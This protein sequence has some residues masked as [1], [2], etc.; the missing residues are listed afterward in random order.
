M[1]VNRTGTHRTESKTGKYNLYNNLNNEPVTEIRYISESPTGL[2]WIG[3]G[4]AGI[5][6]FNPHQK[7]FI[8]HFRNE[9]LDPFSVCSN[10][11]VSIYFDRVG[12]VWCGSYG[13]GVSYAHVENNFFS[14]HLSKAETDQWK[15]ENNISWLG[16]DL[17]GNTWCMLQDVGGFW[18]LDSSFKLTAYR[19]PLLEN[20]KPFIAAVY[21]MLFEGKS[22]AWCTTDRGLY[23]YNTMT[24]RIK[25]IEYPR[26]SNT[27]FG[28]Y[29]SKEI[30]RLQ[31]S[32]ILFST[33]G[34][35]YH[36]RKKN[37]ME[38]IQP[39]SAF[40]HSP[41]KA[42]DMLYEDSS[43]QIYVKD[44]ED[45]FYIISPSKP[46]GNY[47]IKKRLLFLPKFFNFRKRALSSIWQ[48]MPGCFFCTRIT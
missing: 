3:T 9:T 37:G 30:I 5:Y 8:D 36:I 15:K 33:F 48:R 11:I 45:S 44:T 29:W 43:R 20:G 16:P 13:N 17:Q 34:G 46:G 39:F 10:N 28:S 27:L 35:V 2:L 21:H 6:T 22:W 42:F 47:E 1:A 12:N 7:K 18:R 23:L 4:N 32:S 25:Q 38:T 14:K 31:D 40:S 24:N 41:V 19:Q 26:L